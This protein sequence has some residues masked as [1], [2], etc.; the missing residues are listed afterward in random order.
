MLLRM[1]VSAA[2]TTTTNEEGRA[3]DPGC[4]IPS[5]LSVRIRNRAKTWM[6]VS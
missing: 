4:N 2:Q 5:V 1:S 3:G 6:P